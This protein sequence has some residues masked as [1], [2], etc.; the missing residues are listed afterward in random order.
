MSVMAQSD[1]TQQQRL[2]AHLKSVADPGDRRRKAGRILSTA[3]LL[4]VA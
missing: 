4:E 2:K 3:V 1:W